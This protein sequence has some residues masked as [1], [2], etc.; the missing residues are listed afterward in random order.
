MNTALSICHSKI[1]LVKTTPISLA[2]QATTLLTK[3]G[4]SLRRGAHAPYSYLR[5]SCD[6]PA[7]GKGCV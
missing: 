5:A 6:V 4:V 1:R 7:S 3:R 2:R